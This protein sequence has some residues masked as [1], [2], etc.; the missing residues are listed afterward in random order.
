M[1]KSRRINLNRLH[2]LARRDANV[3]PGS[4]IK[5]QESSNEVLHP[6][7]EGVVCLSVCSGNREQRTGKRE[8]GTENT[9]EE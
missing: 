3:E 5:Q 2:F 7:E 6:R 9:N 8:R 4:W 1:N